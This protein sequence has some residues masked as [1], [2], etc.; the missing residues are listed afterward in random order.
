MMPGS[1]LLVG[2]AVASALSRFSW[3]WLRFRVL[4]W[5]AAA[6]LVAALAHIGHGAAMKEGISVG[7]H[8]GASFGAACAAALA[9]LFG[10]YFAAKR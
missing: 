7:I 3:P 6:A 1:A 2:A 5:I 10:G 9:A 8:S 4:R